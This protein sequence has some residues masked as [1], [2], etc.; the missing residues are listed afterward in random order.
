MRV[1]PYISLENLPKFQFLWKLKV[2]NESRHGN[3]LTTPVA[4]G[5]LM[6]FRG[7]KSLI[8]VGGSSNNVY[9]I[10]YDF[11]TLFWRTHHNYTAG[12]R[13]YAGSPTCPGGMTLPLTRA[14]S[15][16]AAGA[17]GVF[18]IRAA[19]AAGERRRRRTRKG[20][21]AA[22]R[23]RGAAAPRAAI[24]AAPIRRQR[25]PLAGRRLRVAPVPPAGRLRLRAAVSPQD[26]R[27]G[28]GPE[29]RVQRGCRWPAARD[30]SRHRRSRARAGPVSS[31]E[32]DGDR[33]DLGQRVRLR[34]DVE[35][36]RWRADGGLCDGLHGRDQ[37]GDGMAVGRRSHCWPCAGH[38]RHGV[39][40]DWRRQSQSTQIRS[41]RSTPR[42]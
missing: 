5:N 20:R 2:D 1:D 28:R 37:T 13:E 14:T 42:P 17:A 23:N 25:R 12:A 32:R 3:S 34:R 29:F 4:L 38:R 11:G 35:H 15:F 18:R 41:S 39:R 33:P 19:A 8:F 30:Y 31:G 9:A 26:G 36:V 16:D 24:V 27:G 10:D 40:L 7:F 6:T 21:P 22:R